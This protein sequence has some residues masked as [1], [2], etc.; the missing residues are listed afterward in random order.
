MRACASARGDP[1]LPMMKRRWAIGA[2]AS[3]KPGF[4]AKAA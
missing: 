3:A 2:R 1:R 4:E